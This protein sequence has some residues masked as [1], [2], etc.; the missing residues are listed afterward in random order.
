LLTHDSFSRYEKA[1]YVPVFRKAL[2]YEHALALKEIGSKVP[3]RVDL[4]KRPS[5]AE[6]ELRESIGVASSTM[7]RPLISYPEVSSRPVMSLSRTS[8]ASGLEALPVFPSEAVW[9][10]LPGRARTLELPSDSDTAL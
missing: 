1:F 3:G 9:V 8:S 2:Q 4:G 6:E 5:K 10:Y 7:I